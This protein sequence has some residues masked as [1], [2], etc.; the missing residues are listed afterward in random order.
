VYEVAPDRPWGFSVGATLE[1]RQGY[2]SAPYQRVSGPLGRRQV[3]LGAIDQF[4]NDDL[5]VLN[6]HLDKEFKF[7]PISV[8]VAVDGF[9]MTNEDVILQRERRLN[10]G[11]ANSVDEVLSPRVFRVGATIRFR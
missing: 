2:V 1:G 9:N 10:I 5:R 6:L 8:V 7:D 3:Q 4:R 11:R